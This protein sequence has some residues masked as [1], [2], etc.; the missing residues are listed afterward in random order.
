MIRKLS[1]FSLFVIWVYLCAFFAVIF[2]HARNLSGNAIYGSPTPIAAIAAGIVAG[3]AFTAPLA[4][5][6][7]TTRRMVQKHTRGPL[8]TCRSCGYDLR[9][10]R[11]ISACPECGA[12][13]SD[14]RRAVLD[15]IDAKKIPTESLERPHRRRARVHP[16]K[17][18]RHR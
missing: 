18:R 11:D 17:P 4:I 16:A 9:G 1:Y 10:A 15:V 14:A 6:M 12:T 13:L 7:F 5:V 8:W 3:S 2:S